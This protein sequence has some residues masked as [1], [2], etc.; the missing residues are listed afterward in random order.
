ALFV[1]TANLTGGSGQDYVQLH[2]RAGEGIPGRFALSTILSRLEKY[3]RSVTPQMVACHWATNYPPGS[4]AAQELN[5]KDYWTLNIPPEHMRKK[6]SDDNVLKE[7]LSDVLHGY[8]TVTYFFIVVGDIDY[9]QSFERL[10]KQGKIVH[11]IGRQHAI[12][13]TYRK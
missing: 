11:I 3:V 12:A 6:G 8:P 5:R 9:S 10:I 13:E 4:P 1:D 7:K 2:T